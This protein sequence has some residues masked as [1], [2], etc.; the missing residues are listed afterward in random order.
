M[1]PPATSRIMFM[2]IL[3]RLLDLLAEL[4]TAATFFCLGKVVQKFPNLIQRIH[5]NGNE[6][7]TH[8]LSHILVK[9]LG[10]EK[11][12]SELAESIKMLEDITGQKVLGHRAPDFSIDLDTDWAFE[13]MQEAGLKYDSSIFPIK[14][15]RYGS[16]EC[17]LTPFLIREDIWEVPLTAYEFGGK[18]YPVLGGGYFRLYPYFISRHVL[19]KINA[20]NRPAVVYSSLRN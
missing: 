8:G 3:L 7:A 14:G 16:P 20:G 4:N 9:Q 5:K 19:K 13:I 12:K 17:G 15:K 10:P 11:F 1:T 18:R 2:I 6:I